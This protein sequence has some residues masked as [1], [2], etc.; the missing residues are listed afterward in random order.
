MPGAV[1]THLPSRAHWRGATAKTLLS[2]AALQPGGGGRAP[3]LCPGGARGPA[4][5][6]SRSSCS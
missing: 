6:L 5:E 3:K 4:D 1:D 2:T